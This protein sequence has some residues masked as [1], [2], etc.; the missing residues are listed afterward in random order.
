MIKLIKYNYDTIVLGGNLSALAYSYANNLPTIINKINL[1]HRFEEN[2][3]RNSLELWNKLFFVLSVNGLN[4]V[5]DKAKKIRIKDE[6]VVVSTKDARVIKFAYKN[7]LIFDDEN[8]SGLPLA[9]KENDQFIVLD[10]ITSRS[11]ELHEHTCIKGNDALVNEL[12]FYPTERVDGARS[13][14]KDMVAISYLDKKQL[15]N[16][17]YSNTSVRFKAMDIL[18]GLGLRGVK[19]G[20]GKRRAISLEVKKRE[21]RKKQMNI[22]KD[23]SKL[24]FKYNLPQE[25][26]CDLLLGGKWLKTA[27]S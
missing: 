20:G 4:L 19:C 15:E 9:K 27:L 12:H 24:K 21:V 11:C 5:G 16:F 22:Y 18:K 26:D 7:L 3:S 23:T 1:P 14:I 17:E 10:W 6:E 13:K 2:N 8:I 25:I